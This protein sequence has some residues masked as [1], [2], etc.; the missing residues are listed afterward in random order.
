LVDDTSGYNDFVWRGR[1]WSDTDTSIHVYELCIST[2]RKIVMEV[3][4]IV[5]EQE[6]IQAV[7][8]AIKEKNYNVTAKNLDP[9]LV[10]VRE[11]LMD[12]GIKFI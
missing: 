9:I 7:D 2:E 11:K 10:E 4:A 8:S 6:F 12:A 5:T 1:Y 3:K